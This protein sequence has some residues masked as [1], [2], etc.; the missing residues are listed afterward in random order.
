MKKSR[1]HRTC[2]TST[3][4]ACYLNQAPAGNMYITDLPEDL[5][6][7][8]LSRVPAETLHQSA[9]YVCKTWANAIRDP[10]FVR[11]QVLRAKPGLFVSKAE[12]RPLVP[13]QRRIDNFRFFEFKNGKFK[14]TDYEYEF[15]GEILGSSGGVALFKPRNNLLCR[16]SL[17]VGNPLTGKVMKLPRPSGNLCAFDRFSNIAF[18]PETG[19]LKV[20]NPRVDSTGKYHWEIVT[21]GVG[22]SWRRIDRHDSQEG[23]PSSPDDIHLYLQRPICV[24]G[25]LYST[26]KCWGCS[27]DESCSIHAID[28]RDETTRCIQIPKELGLCKRSQLMAMG[29][30]LCY[31]GY[32]VR[33]S[34]VYYNVWILKDLDQ[35]EW[36]KLYSIDVGLGENEARNS[37]PI[38]WMENEQ[39]LLFRVTK[40]NSVESH[41]GAAAAASSVILAYNVKTQKRK[42]LTLGYQASRHKVQL[43]INSFLSWPSRH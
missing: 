15:A 3:E 19:E 12:P 22:M 28:I 27:R 16:T 37:I 5:L 29:N 26:S 17:Y 11:N 18:V 40:I 35:N 10:V 30:Y 36:A 14:L 39:E 1:A 42:E 13:Q 4:A 33:V 32:E 34:A 31:I 21:V 24:G 25:F 6:I 41:R 8:I 23:T 20:I 43:H 9:R 7:E 2:M 38:G